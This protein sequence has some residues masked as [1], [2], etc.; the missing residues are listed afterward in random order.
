M[1]ATVPKLNFQIFAEKKNPASVLIPVIPYNT[2]T[3]VV[4]SETLTS[5]FLKPTF[6]LKRSA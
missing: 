6:T 2:K 3:N 4:Y 1:F 5:F